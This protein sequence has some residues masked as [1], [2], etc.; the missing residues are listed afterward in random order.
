[1]GTQNP[2]RIALIINAKDAIKT[3][4]TMLPAS[5]IAWY[6]VWG[7][8][9]HTWTPGLGFFH[10]TPDGYQSV[11]AFQAARCQDFPALHEERPPSSVAGTGH[12]VEIRDGTLYVGF[13]R[14]PGLEG[15]RILAVRQLPNGR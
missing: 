11:Q 5:L 15:T 8:W 13:H 4:L 7:I 6:V 10:A 9:L 3:I 14:N 1:M 2:T 12:V